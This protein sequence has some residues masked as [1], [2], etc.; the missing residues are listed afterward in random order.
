MSGEASQVVQ[1]SMPVQHI[2]NN[3]GT[4]RSLTIFTYPWSSEAQEVLQCNDCVIRSTILFT[5][6]WW[7]IVLQKW[8]ILMS[9]FNIFSVCVHYVFHC[10]IDMNSLVSLLNQ[11]AVPSLQHNNSRWWNGESVLSIHLQHITYR[12]IKFLTSYFQSFLSFL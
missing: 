3:S 4:T 6:P 2:N 10:G 11:R 7:P 5:F 1:T 12:Q 8:Y 9:I